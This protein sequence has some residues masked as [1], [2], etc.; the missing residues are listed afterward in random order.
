MVY[1]F[2]VNLNQFYLNK[3]SIINCL[4]YREGYAGII[5]YLLDCDPDVW[6]TV[7][8]NGRTPLHTA[9]R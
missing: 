3:H 9:G 7:S 8:K 4:L 2:T 6:N 1:Y 5:T